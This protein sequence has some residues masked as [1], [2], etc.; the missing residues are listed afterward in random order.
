M[1]SSFIFGSGAILGKMSG[2]MGGG[3]VG[4]WWV[5]VVRKLMWMKKFVGIGDSCGRLSAS[6]R[7]LLIGGAGLKLMIAC[8]PLFRHQ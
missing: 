7:C 8:Q 6:S 1:R 3:S 5:F 2:G 4:G